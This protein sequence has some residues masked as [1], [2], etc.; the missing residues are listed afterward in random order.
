MEDPLVGVLDPYLVGEHLQDLEE[1]GVGFLHLEEEH[2]LQVGLGIHHLEQENLLQV[3]LGIHHLE[4]LIQDSG[5]TL[6]RRIEA[7]ILGPNLRTIVCQ[8]QRRCLVLAWGLDLLVGLVM[9]MLQ[10]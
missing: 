9:A 5:E 2:L 6:Q 3:G 1:R 7:P 10:L 4:H 8:V